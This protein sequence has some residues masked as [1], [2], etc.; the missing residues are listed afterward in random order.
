VSKGLFIDLQGNTYTKKP[1][2]RMLTP[3]RGYRK[4]SF[5]AGFFPGVLGT[6]IIILVIVQFILDPGR[7]RQCSL[8][9]LQFGESGI[10]RIA[11]HQL[12]MTADVDD[13]SFLHDDDT[14]GFQHGG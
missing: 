6:P 1:L 7:S 13:S 10:Q 8:Q 5:T 9:E 12:F 2:S 3:L 11:V 14:V 4:F